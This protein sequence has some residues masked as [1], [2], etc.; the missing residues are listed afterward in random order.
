MAGNYNIIVECFPGV[1]EFYMGNQYS[2]YI[3]LIG[4]RELT[5]YTWLPSEISI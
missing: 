3:I 2:Y 4:K 1:I 5:G